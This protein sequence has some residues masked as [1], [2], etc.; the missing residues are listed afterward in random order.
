MFNRT[1]WLAALERAVK[2]F[3]QALAAILTAAGVGLLDA[4]W[5]ASCSAAGMA[6]LLS[7]LSSIGSAAATDGSP[8][9]ADERL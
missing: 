4:D 9:L 3:A 7:L 8:S 2:T 1:F 5:L 6:A